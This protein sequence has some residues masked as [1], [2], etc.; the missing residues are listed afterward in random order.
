MHLFSRIRLTFLSFVAFVSNW[1]WLYF[2]YYKFN[3][4]SQKEIIY[5]NTEY[6]IYF[7]KFFQAHIHSYTCN[8]TM[9]YN[10]ML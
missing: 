3:G 4:H 10:T 7:P 5:E 6:L 9:D 2:S 1:K 8:Y